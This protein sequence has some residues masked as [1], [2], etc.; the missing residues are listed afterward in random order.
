MPSADM[1]GASRSISTSDATP[2]NPTL[3]A[4]KES[5]DTTTTRANAQKGMRDQ[6]TGLQMDATARAEADSKRL[7]AVGK[8][9]KTGLFKQEDVAAIL[10]ESNPAAAR[11][12]IERSQ[13]TGSQVTGSNLHGMGLLGAGHAPVV[14]QNHL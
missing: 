5:Q 7:A 8:D 14:A 3:G 6:M 12:M 9:E 11:S 2:R 13:T 4:M 1:V 10:T